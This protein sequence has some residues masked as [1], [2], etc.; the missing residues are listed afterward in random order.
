M[1]VSPRR[2]AVATNV[3][4]LATGW[5]AVIVRGRRLVWQGTIAARGGATVRVRRSYEDWFG[6]ET[7]SVRSVPRRG[8]ACRV[9]AAA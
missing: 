4:W 6:T 1:H 3:P 9:A 5:R 2:V 7:L 8:E